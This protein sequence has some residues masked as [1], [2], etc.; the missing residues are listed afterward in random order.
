MVT[1]NTQNPIGSAD[2]RDLYDNAQVIDDYANS[3]DATTTDRL[4]VERATIAGIDAAA[5]NAIANAGYEFVGDYAAGIEL[6]AYNQVV[7]DTSGEFWRVSGSTALPYTT[8]GTGMS[9]GGAFVTVGDAAL[10]QEVEARFTSRDILLSEMGVSHLKSGEENRNLITQAVSLAA[11][12]GGNIRLPVVPAGQFIDVAGTVVLDVPGLRVFG[13]RDQSRFSQIQYP[14]ALF[15]ITAEDVEVCGFSSKGVPFTGAGSGDSHVQYCAVYVTPTANR[16]K[17]HDIT[18]DS[19]STVVRVGPSAA[20]SDPLVEDVQVYNIKTKDVVFGLLASNTDR[21]QFWGISGGY[22]FLNSVPTPPHLVYIN[23]GV[24]LNYATKGWACHS[25]NGEG[26]Y[27]YQFKG[28]RQGEFSDLTAEDSNGL[29]HPM[30]CEDTHFRNVSS[31]RDTWSSKDQGSIELESTNNNVTVEGFTVEMVADGKAIRVGS[32]TSNSKVGRGR[33]VTNHAVDHLVD[34]AYD[35]ELRGTD[36]EFYDIE[37]VNIGSGRWAVSQGVWSGDGNKITRPKTSGN[38]IG[39]MVRSI[40][41]T[42]SRLEY[43]P[44]DIKNFTRRAIETGAPTHITNLAPLDSNPIVLAYDNADTGTGSG[45]GVPALYTTSGATWDRVFG[46][47]SNQAG[48]LY[49]SVAGNTLTVVDVG[50]ANAEVSCGIRVNGIQGIAMRAI[51]RENQISFNLRSDTGNV[52]IR[53]A[54]TAGGG[55]VLATVAAGITA[56][57]RYDVRGL[58]FSDK[59]ELYID[60]ALIAQATISA[61]AMTT[62]GSVTRHGVISDG[63]PDGKFDGIVWRRA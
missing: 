14:N 10:R 16:A 13:S 22:K 58:V 18:G 60:G 19:I 46:T 41:S 57:R 63:N 11:A 28:V 17:V 8:T 51:D 12:N 59:A 48:L 27:P 40:S 45:L 21:L 54:T 47:W 30:N 53:E 49:S 43:R 35:A 38:V 31:L 25:K 37:T 3:G 24:G 44:A 62:L 42:N 55:A 32:E 5:R 56:G 4:G 23:D 50:Q 39:L 6:T 2:P 9:E 20:G 52:E 15:E 7:R 33:V 34:D 29:L 36:N 61:G 26:S 1:Y